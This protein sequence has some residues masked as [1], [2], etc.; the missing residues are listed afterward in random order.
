MLIVRLGVTRSMVRLDAS[1]VLI[2]PTLAKLREKVA[3]HLPPESGRKVRLSWSR[4]FA[5][6]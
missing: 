1:S 4:N 3:K 5:R 6:K 2:G